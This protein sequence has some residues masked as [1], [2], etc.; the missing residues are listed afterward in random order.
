MANNRLLMSIVALVV[1]VVVNG[2]GSTAF[3]GDD[4]GDSRSALVSFADLDLSTPQSVETAR[5]RIHQTARRLCIKVADRNDRSRRENFILCV[6]AAMAGAV[7]TLEALARLRATSHV[8][9]NSA[10]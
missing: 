1:V 10:K 3:G 2:F 4:V 5:E 6:E 9:N 7:P 8:A